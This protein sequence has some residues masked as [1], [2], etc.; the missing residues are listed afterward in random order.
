MKKNSTSSIIL[1]AL[2][3]CCI[4]LV[5]DRIYV[6]R[7]Q[8][9]IELHLRSPSGIN[10]VDYSDV[11]DDESFTPEE[12]TTIKSFYDWLVKTSRSGQDVIKQFEKLK[13]VGYMPTK[14]D[15][16]TVGWGTTRI[17][18]TSVKLGQKI[19]VEHAQELF[20]KD[21]AYFEKIVDSQ[22]KVPI[23]QGQFDALVS[24]CYNVGD[25]AFK[26]STLLRKLNAKDYVGASEEFQRWTKQKGKVLRGLVVR[27]H[28]EKQ[29]FCK[30]L[31][32]NE[33]NMNG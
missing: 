1:T 3:A 32:R 5:T 23:T 31:T 19:T 27:R 21:L 11:I 10:T 4:W 13:L 9:V 20:E 16:P 25:G 26:N 8:Y 28:L 12:T 29:L 6:P 33:G 24:F 15:V 14:D 2:S 30:D 22:V 17:N 18:G 7:N